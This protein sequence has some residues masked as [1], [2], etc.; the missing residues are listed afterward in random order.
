M[1]G[2]ALLGLMLLAVMS[3][4]GCVVPM[5]FSTKVVMNAEGLSLDYDGEMIVL[6]VYE[7]RD[8]ETTEADRRKLM[9]HYDLAIRD[10]SQKA[11]GT[12]EGSYDLDGVMDV[13]FHR[14]YTYDSLR[15]TELGALM[16]VRHLGDGVYEFQ[17]K[18]AT[19]KEQAYMKKIGIDLGDL[20][21]DVTFEL[22]DGITVVEHNADSEPGVFSSGYSWDLNVGKGERLRMV[23]EVAAVKRRIA[24][25]KERQRKAR[26]QE[27]RLQAEKDRRILTRYA[28]EWEGYFKNVESAKTA[29]FQELK[30]VQVVHAAYKHTRKKLYNGKMKELYVLS[31]ILENRTVSEVDVERYTLQAKDAAGRV[32][33]QQDFKGEW[34]KDK[35]LAPGVKKSRMYTADLDEDIFQEGI[36]KKIE[37]GEYHLY[38]GVTGLKYRSGSFSGKR[39]R[40]D[41]SPFRPDEPRH[42]NIRWEAA[43]QLEDVERAARLKHP[44]ELIPRAS[45]CQASVAKAAVASKPK[46]ANPLEAA[47]HAPEASVGDIGVKATTEAKGDK[48]VQE[49]DGANSARQQA[50][51]EDAATGGNVPETVAGVDGAIKSGSGEGGEAPVFENET[52]QGS[53]AES[54]KSGQAEGEEEAG[55]AL[56]TVGAGLEQVNDALKSVNEVLSIFK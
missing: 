40:L 10:E 29:S 46:E 56:E 41:G 12:Y 24:E 25:E 17:T 54:A 42:P 50:K 9:E 32:V 27:E 35:G 20:S 14:Q 55:G 38:M 51:E 49:I 47:K 45:L 7:V 31:F 6:P 16:E 11:G 39:V 34:S 43:G 28:A 15:S 48:R 33:A 22:S 3:L 8:D 13:E 2:R 19:A 26:E 36:R 44:D 4:G 37:L 1:M 52:G 23:V 53:M 18:R 5:E 30:K 21:G